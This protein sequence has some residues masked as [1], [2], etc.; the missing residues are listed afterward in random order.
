MHIQL[1]KIFRLYIIVNYGYILC[2]T[3]LII[4]TYKII[5]YS[6]SCRSECCLNSIINYSFSCSL[7]RAHF[8]RILINYHLLFGG[9]GVHYAF[10]LQNFKEVKLK[11][12][13]ALMGKTRRQE[14]HVHEVHD[15]CSLHSCEIL[16][17]KE[18]LWVRNR[19]VFGPL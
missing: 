3:H 12:N 8:N 7:T 9:T 10:M 14:S 6:N 18:T 15:L 13:F 17:L 19:S 11:I 16:F 2:S 4:M 5:S 1:F